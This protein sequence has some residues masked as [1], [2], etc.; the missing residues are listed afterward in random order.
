MTCQKNNLEQIFTEAK[1][2]NVKLEIIGKLKDKYFE[3]K[4]KFGK[5]DKISIDKLK[6][7]RNNWF[8]DYLSKINKAED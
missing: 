2:A 8:K 1:N 3:M 4:D 5:T 7:I 6:N